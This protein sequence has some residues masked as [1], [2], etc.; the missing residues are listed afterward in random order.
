M[1]SRR[2]KFLAQKSKLSSA[3]LFAQL[4]WLSSLFC[5]ELE[6]KTFKNIEFN[7][8]IKNKSHH[9]KTKKELTLFISKKKEL[10]PFT[11]FLDV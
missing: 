2:D 6:Y 7:I 9:L 10:L 8:L 1:N 11:L 4:K 5:I 3:V